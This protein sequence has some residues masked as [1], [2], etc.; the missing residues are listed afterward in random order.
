MVSEHS[1]KEMPLYTE[2]NRDLYHQALLGILE[3]R[4]RIQHNC[5]VLQ[6]PALMQYFMLDYRPSSEGHFLVV[7]ISDISDLLTHRSLL[8]CR[9]ISSCA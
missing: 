8:T 4:V 2:H 1:Q 5:F 9:K 3:V 6:V 7:T